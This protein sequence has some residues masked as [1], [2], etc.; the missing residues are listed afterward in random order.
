MFFIYFAYFCITALALMENY[1]FFMVSEADGGKSSWVRSHRNRRG[2]G[3]WVQHFPGH[4]DAAPW[5]HLPI[6][7][8]NRRSYYLFYIIIINR[9]EANGFFSPPKEKVAYTDESHKENH[10]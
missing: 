6:H 8:L 3:S 1:T 4:L 5:G 7:G 2:I 10:L 9:D